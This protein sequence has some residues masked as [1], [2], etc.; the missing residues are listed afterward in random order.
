MKTRITYLTIY[1][2]IFPF[3]LIGQPSWSRVTPL[4]QENT[5]NDIVKIPGTNKLIAAG[6]GSTIMISNNEGESWEFILNP[7]NKENNYQIKGFHFIN[8]DI[9]FIY[10][11]HETILKTEDGGYN[12]FEV[13]G[14]GSMY[15]WK[16]INDLQFINSS[17]GFGLRDY[18]ILMKSTDG[19]DTWQEQSS[20][21]GYHL[22]AIDFP[23]DSTGYIIGNSVSSFL[24]TMNSGATWD[25]MVFELPFSNA[26][27]VD[28]HMLSSN[29]G[30]F[31]GT[32]SVPNN[33][34]GMIFKTADGGSSWISVY[35]DPFLYPKEI[36]FYNEN[37]GLSGGDKIMYC[38]SALITN[39]GG[40]SWQE[41]P[42]PGFSFHG[43]KSVCYLDQNN[44]FIVGAYGNYFKSTNGGGSWIEK[45]ERVVN[46]DF[47][48]VQFC[49]SNIGY[50]FG[51]HQDGGLPTLALTKSTDGGQSWV[52]KEVFFEAMEGSMYFL[53]SD[54]GYVVTDGW[55]IQIFKTMDGGSSWEELDEGNFNFTPYTIRFF[56]NNNGLIAGDSKIIKTS[57]GGYEWDLV[58]DNWNVDAFYDIHYKSENSILIAGS[59][60]GHKLIVMESTD[61]GNNWQENI[62]YN[63]KAAKRMFFVDEETAFLACF[64]NSILKSNDGGISW[65]ETN[66]LNLQHLIYFNSVFFPTDQ[67]GY[68]VGDGSYETLLKTH[69][70]GENWFAINSNTAADLKDVY[71]HDENNGYV[72]GEKGLINKTTSGGITGFE[73]IKLVSPNSLYEI[74]PNPCTSKVS[75][76]LN[77]SGNW[78]IGQIIL[79][80][81]NGK[82][83][84]NYI[85]YKS[86][87]KLTISTDHLKPGIY[88]FQLKTSNGINETRKMIKL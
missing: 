50:A 80:D 64:P 63:F 53:N 39:N 34:Y 17:V 23:N 81:Q 87:E 69:D 27:L 16:C 52:I 68:A 66:I 14:S 54:T 29:T 1:A 71:F 67:I 77:P 38:S 56:D 84:Q 4:P 8:S 48:K 26:T 55:G 61:G 11:G 30:F 73:E 88:F 65:Y 32:Y 12:W 10:G 13:F 37:N 5:L 20:P 42:L 2:I 40:D 82:L 83:V 36:N 58:Y 6:Y 43:F 44:A 24:K 59:Y 18:G 51:Y 31:C 86:T 9:G 22:H 57:N 15:N 62:F 3:L 49:N 46:G 74:L 76:N 21:V 79:Y 33:Y 78:S 70:G 25:V 19:G 75:I 47:Y 85:V 60:S 72:F 7:A 35:E 41:V 45:S 28:I